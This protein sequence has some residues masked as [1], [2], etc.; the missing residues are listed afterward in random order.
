MLAG[1]FH[2]EVNAMEACLHPRLELLAPQELAALQL[3]RLRATVR[4]AA[5]APHY[6][7]AFAEAG[8]KPGQIKTLDDL[9][10][11]PL[12]VKAD[13]R[14]GFPDGFLAVDRREVVR[15]HASSGT[16]GTPT[17]VYH[18]QADLRSWTEL[19]ARSLFMT[20]LRPADVFQNMVGY[21]LFTGGLGLH[22]GAEALGAMV[23]PAGVGNSRRQVA[24]MRQFKTNALHM[25]PSYALKLYET[26]QE[27]NLDPRRHTSLRLAILGAEPH[28]EQTRRR[29]EELYGV[30]A[31]NSYGLSELNGPGVAMECPAQEG[32]HLWEDAFLLE[33]IDPETLEPVAEG[34][35]GELVLTTL[36]RRA[37]PLIRYRTR[38]LAS[39]LPGACVCG[40]PHRRLSRIEGRSDDMFIIKGVNV[41][42]MQVEAVLMGTREVGGNYL[43]ELTREGAEEVMTVKVEAAERARTLAAEEMA[44]LRKRL[45]AALKAEILLTPRVELVAPDSLPSGPG[46]AQR[47]A[48]RR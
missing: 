39:V 27:M 34:Q 13:L 3:K 28:S 32:M 47:V 24:L 20:G 23:I 6:Q 16:T 5:L 48:D 40:R 46:K 7:R 30:K 31:F 21:G 17:A 12:T 1:R 35:T 37:M 29:V 8:L 22:Y 18:S 9:R 10:R 44:G 2:P 42:P 25:I 26:F 41:F 36:A 11:L 45:A 38:D 19:C 15:L 33:V 14:A 43:I 4:R